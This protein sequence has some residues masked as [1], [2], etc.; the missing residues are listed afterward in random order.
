MKTTTS[1]KLLT[2]T[3]TNILQSLE[4]TENQK[5]LLNNN[6]F[7]SLLTTAT[8][9]NSCGSC[10]REYQSMPPQLNEDF[11]SNSTDATLNDAKQPINQNNC[12]DLPIY[13][14]KVRFL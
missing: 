14:N 7:N 4:N 12:T 9:A 5:N 10:Q 1:A 2:Q 11:I 13:R 8:S 3:Q 6:N